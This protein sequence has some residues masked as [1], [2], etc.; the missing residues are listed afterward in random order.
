[1]PG[2]QKLSIMLLL[3]LIIPAISGCATTSNATSSNSGDAQ[4]EN[5]ES[6]F[7]SLSEKNQ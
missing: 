1:M 6:D 2:I 3:L 4:R 7:N 5:V